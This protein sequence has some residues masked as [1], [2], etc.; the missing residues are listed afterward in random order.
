MDREPLTEAATT[1]KKMDFGDSWYSHSIPNLPEPMRQLFEQ[2]SGITPAQVIEHIQR[3]RS[4]AFAVCPYPCIGQSRW[5]N[6]ALSRHALYPDVLTRLC[7][8]ATEGTVQYQS[9]GMNGQKSSRYYTISHPQKL[10]D[11]GCCLAQDL[12]KLAVDGAPFENLYGL[13]IEEAF[14]KISYEVLLDRDS[15]KSQF[16]V[17]DMLLA[18]DQKSDMDRPESCTGNA[19]KSPI[20]PLVPLSSLEKQISIIAA[21]SIFHLYNYSD[22][23]KLAKRMVR[24]LSPQ[25]GFMILGRHIGSSVPGEYPGM[26][27]DGTRYAH[28]VAS[29]QRFWDRVAEEV[30]DGCRFRVEGTM[31]EEGVILGLKWSE[32]NVRMVRFGVWRE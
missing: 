7:Q 29:F 26:N 31:D 23:L 6:L 25:P 27:D 28:D 12:R 13:D 4:R 2:Y 10:L 5:L 30:G 1:G 9:L 11:M 18:A 19:S 20:T 3:M 16:V 21:N 8:S 24:L 14:I 32:P 22:Q 17:A 15:L